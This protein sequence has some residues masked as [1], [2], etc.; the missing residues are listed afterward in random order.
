MHACGILYS[1]FLN[2]AAARIRNIRPIPPIRGPQDRSEQIDLEK[3]CPSPQRMP[4]N[5]DSGTKIGLAT[6]LGTLVPFWPQEGRGFEPTTARNQEPRPRPFGPAGLFSWGI[7]PLGNHSPGESPGESFPGESPPGKSFP[8]GITPLGNH[9]PGESSCWGSQ[10]VKSTQ[11]PHKGAQIP[12]KASA[13]GFR[14]RLRTRVRRKV[15]R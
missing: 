7:T 4:R 2:L 11:V 8:W 3:S 15:F 10:Q 1:A 9:P 13:Q 5:L 12:H 6:C 14:T